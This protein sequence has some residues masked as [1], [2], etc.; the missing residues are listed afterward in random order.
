MPTPVHPYLDLAGMEALRHVRLRP[1]GEAEEHVAGPH[2]SFRGTAVGSLPTTGNTRREMTFA[3]WTGRFS[4]ERTGI[5][6]GS[7]MRSEIC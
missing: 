5:S 1:R 3:W 6:S 7:M 2:K 4:R